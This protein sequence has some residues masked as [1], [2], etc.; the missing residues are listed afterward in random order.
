MLTE[1]ISA[2]SGLSIVWLAY[3]ALSKVSTHRIYSLVLMYTTITQ[4]FSLLFYPLVYRSNL[5]SD[6][7]SFSTRYELNST[8]LSLISHHPFVGIGPN[9][10]SQYSSQSLIP[11]QQTYT[12]QPVHHGLLLIISETGIIGLVLVIIWLLKLQ[13]AITNAKTPKSAFL[14]LIALATIL[15]LDH[16]PLTLQTGQLLLLLSLVIILLKPDIES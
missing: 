6:N 3:F 7:P 13:P 15:V 16:Y 8:A 14:P 1:S 4:V 9:L 11:G 2:L 5:L 10:F 12:L